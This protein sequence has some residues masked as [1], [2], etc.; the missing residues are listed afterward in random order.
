MAA[1]AGGRREAWGYGVWLAFAVIVGVPEIWAWLSQDTAWWP[2]ISA[3]IGDLEHR[4]PGVAVFV[5]ALIILGV[6][7]AIRLPPVRTGVLPP[8]GEAQPLLTG[9][10]DLP[11]RTPSGRLTLSDTAVRE[12][13]AG[14]YFFTSLVLIS[15]GTGI[16]AAASGGFDEFA[17]GRTLYGLI[18]LL[19]VLLPNLMALPKRFALDV[20]FPTLFET[21]RNLE[22][23]IPALAYVVAAGL[24]VLL[25]HLVL[26]P[27][28]EIIPDVQRLHKTYQCHPLEP[29]KHPLTPKQ[30]NECRRI[31]EAEVKPEPTSP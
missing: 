21:M 1:E 31:D 4:W 13:G 5:V 19:W 27:W 2:T 26:Y 29:T 23:R 7:G 30:Q 28:P 17:V 8:P 9:S 11:W 24:A 22:R 14:A 18:A 12:L 3:T 20:P 15:I 16:A 10:A 6:Y 25:I